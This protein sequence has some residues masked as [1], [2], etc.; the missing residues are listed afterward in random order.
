MGHAWHMRRGVAPSMRPT[1]LKAAAADP[2]RRASR[3][4]PRPLLSHQG[5]APRRP[6]CAGGVAARPPHLRTA[7][8][9]QVK[10]AVRAGS[11]QGGV[12]GVHVQQLISDGLQHLRSGQA[13]AAQ[14][15]DASSRR[16]ALHIDAGPPLAL[17]RRLQE[18]QQGAGH[19]GGDG[20]GRGAP[21]TCP[22]WHGPPRQEC[23]ARPASSSR[24]GRRSPPP[25]KSRAGLGPMRR[26]PPGRGQR[27]RTAAVPRGAGRGA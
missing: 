15:S 6:L 1:T 9:R 22:C 11:Q 26:L 12:G 18:P 7:L 25:C 10:L 27:P 19:S 3:V 21:H 24:R 16:R 20:G 5:R 13:V 14:C 8:S 2:A 23:P 4:H 17:R